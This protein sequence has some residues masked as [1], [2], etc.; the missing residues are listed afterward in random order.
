[1]ESDQDPGHSHSIFTSPVHIKL[2][3]PI[4]WPV[5]GQD[6][7]PKEIQM[8]PR[9]SRLQLLQ[10][11]WS[12]TLLHRVKKWRR[13]RSE[14][15]N[16]NRGERKGVGRWNSQSQ[17]VGLPPAAVRS[18]FF[19]DGEV[20]LSGPPAAPTTVH[21]WSQ[22]LQ[23]QIR[24]AWQRTPQKPRPMCQS[25]NWCQSQNKRTHWKEWQIVFIYF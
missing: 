3:C 17:L 1:M 13:R 6:R 15:F 11:L 21:V 5:K 8:F 23:A 16:K 22:E 2:L 12:R 14:S 19:N 25:C 7:S 4:Q 24:K 20:D 18:D 10:K 9:K